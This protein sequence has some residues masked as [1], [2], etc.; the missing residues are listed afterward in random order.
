MP[1]LSAGQ[2]A[3]FI[4][5]AAGLASGLMAIAG[6]RATPFA[7]PLLIIAPA[8][9][10]IASLGWGT[11]AGLVAAVAASAL[12]LFWHGP[13]ALAVVAGLLFAPAALA[14]H[15]ANL[16]Q[17]DAVRGGLSWFPVSQVLLRLMGALGAG[18]VIAGLAMGYEAASVIDAFEALFAEVM[19]AN[20]D[21]AAPDGE[22]V[23]QSAAFYAAMLP[24]VVPGMW[25]LAH[26]LV[27][28]FAAVVTARSGLLARPP[29]DIA[30][31]AGLPRLALAIPLLGIAGM[32]A[33]ASPYYE[34]AAI[35]T[36]LGV[37]GF[38]LVGLA[39]LH[40][41][42]RGRP[43]RQMI[44]FF[45][46]LLLIVFG[47]PILVLA[48]TGAVRCLRRPAVMPPPN[49]SAGPGKSPTLQ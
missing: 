23:K 15:L 2:A 31:T 29:E 26:V 44:L 45:S 30:Q 33:F 14:G 27:M 37:A 19:K 42:T 25:L 11:I 12:G 21:G 10:Y 6:L 18:F 28:H 35:A 49:G 46:Y 5:I 8:A 43:S 17:P 48:V 20:P 40:L 1:K 47:F 22:L 4:A 38:G 32:A 39:E 16:A 24:A 7:L 3:I 9:V 36:G 13:A 41:S 34:I